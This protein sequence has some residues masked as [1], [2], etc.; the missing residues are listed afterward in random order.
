[1]TVP[2]VVNSI[3]EGHGEVEALPILLRR[4][5]A[6]IEPSLPLDIRRPIRVQRGT[7]LKTGELERVVNLAARST[8]SHGAVFVL[9]DADDDCPATLGPALLERARAARPDVAVS[10][11]LA[12]REFE[13]WFLAGAASLGGRRG[14]PEPLSPPPHPEAVRDAKGW[15]QGRR[16]DGLAYSPTIDQPALSATVDVDLVRAGSPS[17]D[18]L[19]RDFERFLEHTRS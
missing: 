15:L 9:I 18:K 6:A 3:V 2:F 1:M 4:V 7:L 17:F 11:V 8:T 10:V 12:M 13:A 19:W 14:L 5:A 16:T